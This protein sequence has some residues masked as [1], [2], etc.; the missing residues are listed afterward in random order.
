MVAPGWCVPPSGARPGR[1]GRPH[2]FA[3]GIVT[4]A[5]TLGTI[6]GYASF[7]VPTGGNAL[8]AAFEQL[9]RDANTVLPLD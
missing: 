3:A 9:L 7:A 8:A 5:W 4:V 2:S 6:R 1:S